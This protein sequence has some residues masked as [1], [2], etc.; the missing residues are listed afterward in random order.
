MSYCRTRRANLCGSSCAIDAGVSL[1]WSTGS[2]LCCGAMDDTFREDFDEAH[3]R[4]A[5]RA[6]AAPR[7]ELEQMV[8]VDEWA[9]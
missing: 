7:T 3:Y 1:Q 2:A 9:G 8:V 6:M 5:R 4:W